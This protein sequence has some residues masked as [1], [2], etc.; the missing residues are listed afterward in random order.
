[1][2]IF[3]K[4]TDIQLQNENIFAHKNANYAAKNMH[5]STFFCYLV[6]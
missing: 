5:L 2:Y 3:W 1:M 6:I 4:A